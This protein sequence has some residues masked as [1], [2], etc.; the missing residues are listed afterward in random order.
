M[1]D[2][3]ESHEFQVCRAAIHSGVVTRDGGEAIVVVG[4]PQN[5]F[6]ALESHGI[7]SEE[8]GPYSRACEMSLT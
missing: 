8:N 6:S 4:H 1:A 5:Y 7:H 2:W 3:M